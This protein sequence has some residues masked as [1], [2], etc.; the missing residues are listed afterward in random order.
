MRLHL[1]SR[2]KIRA[3]SD[4]HLN[5][6]IDRKIEENIRKYTYQGSYEISQ[7][8]MELEKEWDINKVLQINAASLALLG[9]GFSLK[10]KRWLF[11]SGTIL[12]TLAYVSLNGWGPPINIFRRMG[13]RTRQEIDCEIYAMKF[14]RGDFTEIQPAGK[15]DADMAIKE[16][17]I[18]VS[19]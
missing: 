14:L 16:A 9:I 12:L 4:S 8:I 18:A 6:E 13:Y 10:N 3:A 1:P 2:D 5:W 7:R 11:F 19:S 17:V 15:R